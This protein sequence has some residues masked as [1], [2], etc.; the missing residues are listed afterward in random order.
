LAEEIM[1]SRIIQNGS[2]IVVAGAESATMAH[3]LRHARQYGWQI[4]QTRSGSMARR[5][6]ARLNPAVVILDVNLDGESGWLTA[7]K[8]L[9]ERP[10]QEV[11]LL[12]PDHF[13]VNRRLASF[14]GVRNVVSRRDVVAA[15]KELF[16][17]VCQCPNE[18][19]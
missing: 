18:S 9:L 19:A 17:P 15:L 13:L 10:E 7:A 3:C 5:L 2:R 1:T 4:H 8:L 16:E 6:A 12:A 11:L 14:L